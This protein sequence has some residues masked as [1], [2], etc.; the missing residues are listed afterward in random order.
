MK[1]ALPIAVLL[2][3]L[4]VLAQSTT[5]EL[6]L[7]VTDPAGLG[8]KS[9]VELVSQ[10]NE[11][12]HTF[13][14]DD[15]GKLDAKRLPYGIYQVQIQVQGFAHTSESV[16]IRSALPLDRTIRLKVASVSESVSVSATA[17]LVDPY[18]A[19]SVNEMGLQTIQNRLAA[20]P[21]RSMQ[22][23]VNTEPGWLY[24]GNAVLH[25]R[26]SEYQTQFVVDGI[27]LTDNRSPGFGPEVEADDI[28]SLKIYTGGFPAEYGRKMGGVIEVNTLKN[29]DP[30]FHGQL[31]LFGGTYAT[32][33]I[34]TQ[35]QYTWGRN[36]FG[37]SGSGNMTGHYLNPV[38]PENYTN[39]GTTGSF[40]VTYE[41]DLTHK[42]RLTLIVRHELAR[43][44]IPNE[45]VQENG[46]YLPNGTWQDGT[47][48]P[49]ADNNG[50][51]PIGAP[52]DCTLVPGGQLQN[53]N[54]FETIGSVSYQH[55]LSADTM[56]WLRG[57]AR[58]NSNNFY[59]NPESWPIYV[60]QHNDFKEIYFNGSV[61][62]HQ[63]R[64]EWKAG[65]ESD[66][67]FL[68]ENFSDSIPDCSGPVLPNPTPP[69]PPIPQDPQCP[70]TLGFFDPGSA[71]SFF[72]QQSRPDLE[73]SAYVQDLIRLGNWTV[74]AG[75]R[76][77]HYQ[78]L[79]NQNALSPRVSVSRY[80]RDAGVNVHAAYDRIFQPP[81]FDNI[82]LSSST[83]V[84][85]FDPISLRQNVLPSHG[86]YFEAGFTRAFVGK[87]RLD[88]NTFRRQVNNYADDDAILNSA[89]GFPIAFRKAV[90]YGAEAKLEVLHW[91]RFSGF[92]SYSWIVGNCWLPVV[93]GLLLGSASGVAVGPSGTLINTQLTGRIPDSQDQR[94][95]IRGRVRYQV[96]P[97]LWIAVGADYN[98]GL[99]FEAD[100]SPEQYALQYGQVMIDHLNFNLGRIHPYFTQNASVGADLYQREKRSVRLQA[101]ATNLSN[102][103]EVIDFGGLFSGNAVGPSRQY[104]L[105]LVTTF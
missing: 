7:T 66:A 3:P 59:S 48:Q 6:R 44:E 92:G 34:N 38:V 52:I 60:A 84:L 98:S 95:T 16:E 87:L 29:A 79:V 4:L 12:R 40:S 25:P 41:R 99:P 30:G 43:Y 58:D 65:I 28:E 18:R 63:G 55:V 42:D 37:V 91:G 67:L 68:H 17:T 51:C 1:R 101:D 54:N 61:S 45:L 49:N 83:A 56:G 11:Y 94:N 85:D 57:M 64:Q 69:G 33:G 72:F 47:W 2:W 13:S 80:F 10:G 103:L 82:L 22:D 102:T 89:I 100:L 71:T 9:M 15:Q 50:G 26:G 96:V 14:T 104:T 46:A 39:D 81:A 90:L 76:W 62:T 5:G 75:L 86:D 20:I 31:T 73:Q 32:G 93:G 74:N 8:L 19:G 21:G 105:R 36:T 53:G 24:E 88:A 70:I 23:L 35:D 97:R 27:P 77:D 78:L